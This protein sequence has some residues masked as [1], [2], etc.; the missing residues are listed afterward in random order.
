MD[1]IA[2]LEEK[3]ARYKR[4]LEDEGLQKTLDEMDEHMGLSQNVFGTLRERDQYWVVAKEG[5]RA[6]SEKFRGLVK[7]TSTALEQQQEN[8]TQGEVEY[9]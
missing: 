9:E 1:H 7:A 2:D 5:A 4:L 3:L 8:K 6:Y